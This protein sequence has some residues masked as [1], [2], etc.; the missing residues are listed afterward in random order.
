[1]NERMWRNPATQA[2]VRLLQQRGVKVLDVE[3][4]ELACGVIGAGRLCSLEKIVEAVESTRM[5]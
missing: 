3:E 4:G 1:M 2:N 5:S